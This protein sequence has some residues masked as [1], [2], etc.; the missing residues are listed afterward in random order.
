MAFVFQDRESAYPNKFLVTPETG[1][2]YYIVL[3]RADEPVVVGTPL[4]AETF[5]ALITDL[6]AN[7]GI[8]KP[9]KSTVG[10]Y[11][12]VKAVDENGE[13]TETET[14]NAVENIPITVDSEGYTDISGLRQPTGISVV[15]TDSN[16]TFS[17]ELQGGAKSTSVVLFDEDGYPVSIT[18]DDVECAVSWEGFDA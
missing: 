9:E 3:E 11:I 7:A 18:T 12:R 6:Y 10:Q 14:A 2:P 8:A 17:V 5:N 4:N 16:Y 1:D 15:K 13:I